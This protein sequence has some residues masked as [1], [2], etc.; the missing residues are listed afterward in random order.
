[1][2]RS[3]LIIL[4]IAAATIACLV[5]PGVTSRSENELLFTVW[6]MPFEDNLFRDGYARDFEK[7]NPGVAVNYET[8]PDVTKKYLVWHLRGFG[9]DVMRL[10]ITDYH[11]M[12]SIGA[13][14]PLDQF[15][16]DPEFGLTAEEQADFMPSLWQALEIDGERYAI[17]SDNAQY[18]LYY[19]KTIFDRYNAK[20]PEDRIPYPDASWTWEDLRS[21]ADRLTVRDEH[22]ETIQY[23]VDFDLWAWPFMAF[24]TQAGG[25]LWDEDQT[26]TLINSPR[27]LETLQF[28]VDLLPHAGPLRSA[29]LKDSATG[30][31]KFFVTGQT[32]ILLDGSWRAPS[33]ELTNP[34]LDFAIAPLPHHRE[35][36]V[37]SGSVLWAISV[38]S[39]NK[40]LAWKMVKFITNFEQSLRYW[41]AL[42]VAPPSR[43]SVVRDEAFRSTRGIIDERGTV[44]SPAMPRERWEDRGQWLLYAT[45]P[46]PA[47]G[48][49]P[50]FVPV[51]PYQK[52]LEE[53]IKTMLGR[54]V[55]PH[56][57][58][59]LSELLDATATDV[60]RVIDRDRLARGAPAAVR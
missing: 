49:M 37:V 36:A 7:Q 43:L 2:R 32:A 57:Q 24:L 46:D 9:A 31:D 59:S 30:P 39:R 42:R 28:I 17:P 18:G 20:H 48:R 47:T 21:A 5:P 58:E 10:P 29:D 35:R 22:G 14:E 1:M 34:D 27:G 56:R 12:V 19:N 52:D 8:Y 51:T 55:S 50:G 60:H 15:I 13:L 38:H 53:K 23:G 41:D 3:H 26:T 45:T 16:E 44:R 54:A 6:G 25:E 4:L 40:E 11:A 33:L